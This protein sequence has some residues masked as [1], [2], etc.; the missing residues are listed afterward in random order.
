VSSHSGTKAVLAALGANAFIA[1]TKF[2]AWALTGA[3]SMLAEG[4]HS[5][6]DTGN[7][8]LL[9]IGG[10]SAKRAANAEHPFGFGRARYVNAFLVS[11]ILFSLGGLFAIYEAVNKLQEVRAGHPNELLE[12]SWWWVPLLVL[13]A[14]IVAES[15]SFRTAIRESRPAKGRLGWVR[16]IRTTKSPELPV[17]LLEDFAA[18]LGLVFALMGVGMTLLT[19]NGLWDA[20]GTGLIGL[21]LIAV[22]IMLAVETRSFLLGESATPEVAQAIETALAGADGVVRVVHLKTLHLGPE[23]ILVA[24]KIAVEPTGSAARVAQVI[25]NA[26]AAIRACQPTATSIYLEPDIDQGVG[27]A[28]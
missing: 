14:A 25:N 10:R 23:E 8:V 26:E 22:A 15:F 27:V 5:V 12:G 4:V 3:A 28:P 21:L 11:V 17:I 7:Q 18:L 9:L 16:F 2:A 1:A 13:V 6:A 20:A 19:H 24:A